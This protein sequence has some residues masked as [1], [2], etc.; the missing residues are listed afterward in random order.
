M[1]VSPSLS[2]L[3]IEGIN[4][5]ILATLQAY[6]W[7]QQCIEW[8]LKKKVCSMSSNGSH[9]PWFH[10]L[11]PHRWPPFPS[12]K[13]SDATLSKQ[14]WFFFD[15]F[16]WLPITL[17]SNYECHGN[18]PSHMRYAHRCILVEESHKILKSTYREKHNVL[19]YHNFI[20]IVTGN[21]FKLFDFYGFFLDWT[22]FRYGLWAK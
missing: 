14:L 3:E 6:S 9:R 16:A 12:L 4:L 18:L 15:F 2:W 17:W 7:H 20:G 21:I 13:I 19:M 5:P 11:A 10:F 8:T 1:C 22:C